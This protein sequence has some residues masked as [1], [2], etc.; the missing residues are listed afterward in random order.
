MQDGSGSLDELEFVTALEEMGFGEETGALL[1]ARCRIVSSAIV[2][3][4]MVS[5][6]MVS[7]AMVSGAI[8]SGTIVSGATVSSAT[9]SLWRGAA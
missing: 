7:G 8:V 9:G 5:G 6:A 1:M 4:A 2:S 3:S